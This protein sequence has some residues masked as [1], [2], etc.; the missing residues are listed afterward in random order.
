MM[1]EELCSLVRGMTIVL[2]MSVLSLHNKSSIG[3]SPNCSTFLK[4]QFVPRRQE[5]GMLALERHVTSEP[6]PR[7]EICNAR[8]FRAFERRA[9]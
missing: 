8:N 4:L 1:L 5:D 9:R 6:L 3:R 7:A 2:K